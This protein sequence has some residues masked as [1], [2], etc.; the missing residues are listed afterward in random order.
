M[1]N[2]KQF[3][4][5][6]VP[7]A[8]LCRKDRHNSHFLLKKDLKEDSCMWCIGKMGAIMQ[9]EQLKAREYLKTHLQKLLLSSPKPLV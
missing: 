9:K 2:N 1:P 4:M 5:L 6:K 3:E 8:E 7:L